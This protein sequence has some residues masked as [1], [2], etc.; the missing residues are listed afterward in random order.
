M[1]ILTWCIYPVHHL[2][3]GYK[4][5]KYTGFHWYSS[6]MKREYLL[7]VKGGWFISSSSVNPGMKCKNIPNRNTVILCP[8]C[9]LD[10]SARSFLSL[11]ISVP[12]DTALVYR[13]EM[14]PLIWTDA[15]KIIDWLKMTLAWRTTG[16]T[17]PKTLLT[18]GFGQMKSP[19]RP[20]QH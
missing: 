11:I 7:R 9:H 14:R 2:S 6:S 8:W 5:T 18:N 3:W 12:R 16:L 13:R 15:I 1:T 19:D 4:Y 17:L 20:T 10:S